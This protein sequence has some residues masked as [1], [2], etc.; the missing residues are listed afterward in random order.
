[1]AAN[2]FVVCEYFNNA[3]RCLH[4]LAIED[5]PAP[6]PSLSDGTT[7]KEGALAL[8][9]LISE[10]TTEKVGLKLARKVRAVSMNGRAPI[11]VGDVLPELDATFGTNSAQWAR[12]IFTHLNLKP[13]S[14][15]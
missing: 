7:T 8:Q 3:G 6:V 5:A 9:A 4:K 1:M 2:T 11:T 12:A 10:V 15:Q 13:P 14:I